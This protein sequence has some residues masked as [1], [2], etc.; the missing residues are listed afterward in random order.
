MRAL[1]ERAYRSS[2]I[3]YTAVSVWLRYK[4]PA[5]WD[6]L[7]GVD[8]DLRDMTAIHERNAE[9]IFETATQLKGLISSGFGLRVAGWNTPPAFGI[10]VPTNQSIS[11]SAHVSKK[12]SGI[13]PSSVLTP[14]GWNVRVWC[15][16][17]PRGGAHVASSCDSEKP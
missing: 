6:R 12:H 14:Y 7:R 16:C 17:D 2:R 9:Q 1:A 4:V 11:G 10:F 15:T 8:P 5:W 13:Q 3:G